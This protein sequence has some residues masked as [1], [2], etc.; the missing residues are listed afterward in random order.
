MKSIFLQIGIQR[1]F[2]QS[3]ENPTHFLDV[4]FSFVFGVDKVIIQIHNDKDI[5]FFCKDLIDIAL[6]CCRNIGKSKKYYLIFK[7]TVSSLESS[8]LL[9]SFVNSHLVIGTSKVKLDKPPCLPQLI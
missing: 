4:A 5:K 8:F 2:L 1:E 7:I 3:V 9:I 6:K